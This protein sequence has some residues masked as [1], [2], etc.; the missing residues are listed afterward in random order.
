[1]YTGTGD[2]RRRGRHPRVDSSAGRSTTYELSPAAS[3]HNEPAPSSAAAAPQRGV[4]AIPRRCRGVVLAA[5]SIDPQRRM[6]SMASSFASSRP[7][8]I[9]CYASR[10]NGDAPATDPS[11]PP[12]MGPA[13]RL[14]IDVTIEGDPRN[15]DPGSVRKPVSWTERPS[16]RWT[17]I[18]RSSVSSASARLRARPFSHDG[19]A[20]AAVSADGIA[21]FEQRHL[22]DL[23]SFRA[24]SRW[25]VFVAASSS[26]GSSS[27]P[28]AG[29][30]DGSRRTPASR[31]I[32]VK[33]PRDR[34]R[35]DRSL[36]DRAPSSSDASGSRGPRDD[37]ERETA[38]SMS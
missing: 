6:T 16:E 24:G 2:A 28:V 14:R 21:V 5:L 26:D 30:R 32:S 23:G 19:K 22:A 27:L 34:A 20:V 15:A 31:G 33:P 8:S 10:I 1:M 36:P 29:S 11:G 35:R 13:K 3:A 37:A 17:S 18:V 4:P 25:R 38:C 7:R 12:M 9:A